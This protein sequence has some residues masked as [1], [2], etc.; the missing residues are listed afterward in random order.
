MFLVP[1]G[2]VT[3]FAIVAVLTACGGGGGAQTVSSGPPPTTNSVTLN[4][5]IPTLNTD[6]SQLTDLSGFKVIYGRSTSDLS[7]SVTI[8]NP[9]VDTYQIDNL[10]SGT[11]Y[12][13]IVS[14][15][16]DGTESVPTNPLSQT[17]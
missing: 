9:T 8:N 12:F 1:R 3:S 11:W 16:S 14:L 7:Q 10:S 13:E 15:A 5:T 4:W 6:G 17:I 2:L